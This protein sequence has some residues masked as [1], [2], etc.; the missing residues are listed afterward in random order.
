[1]L[2][3]NQF[4][5][6]TYREHITDIYPAECHMNKANT[7]DK[8]ISFFDLSI[9]VIDSNIRASVCDQVHD[10]ECTIATFPWF[11]G[12]VRILQTCF[13]GMQASHFK[14]S[15]IDVPRDD[16]NSKVLKQDKFTRD[17]SQL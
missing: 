7:S 8:Y 4:T 17:W 2:N 15:K 3:L 13:Y 5:I 9:K 1:M 10:I 14:L 11:N 12:D 6:T 16:W